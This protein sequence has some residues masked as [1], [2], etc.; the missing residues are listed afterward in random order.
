ML[1]ILRHFKQPKEAYL[2]SDR[3]LYKA[4]ASPRVQEID[5]LKQHRHPLQWIREHLQIDALESSQWIALSIDGARPD[6]QAALLNAVTDAY[7]DTFL[8][9]YQPQ[10]EAELARTK[11]VCAK[12]REERA[13]QR[14]SLLELEEKGD[15]AGASALRDEIVVKEE[16]V[17][18]LLAALEE[19]KLQ[20]ASSSSVGPL[21]GVGAAAGR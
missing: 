12:S 17:R 9:L 1:N 6:E 11:A 15:A 16:R 8:E 18:R 7:L 14:R 10:A 2:T 20:I 21:D 3:V 5:W 4:F 19:M 13:A